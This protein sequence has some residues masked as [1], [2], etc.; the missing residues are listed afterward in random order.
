MKGRFIEAGLAG[1][2]V[3]EPPDSPA[4]RWFEPGLDYL[5]WHTPQEAID[6]VR[7]ASAAPGEYEAMGR[8]LRAKMLERHAAPVFWRNVLTRM[9][10]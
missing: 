2:V 7:R 10:L 5:V 4:P 8:R 3:L 1:A 6:L 9:G